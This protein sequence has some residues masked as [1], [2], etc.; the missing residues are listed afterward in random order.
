MKDGK[1]WTV[2]E[3]LT[4]VVGNDEL[5]Y[6]VSELEKNT[7]YRFE[8]YAITSVDSETGV[9]TYSSV[10]R[11][12]GATK[13]LPAV[14]SVKVA[15][16][17]DTNSYLAITWTTVVPGAEYEIG[18]WN[19]TNRN[20]RFIPNLPSGVE[21]VSITEATVNGRITVTALLSGVTVGVPFDL[22]IRMAL[23][24]VQEGAV[25]LGQQGTSARAKVNV[26]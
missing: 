24:E 22:A 1:V 20:D 12:N 5:S 15:R 25:V 17:L 21:V 4:I 23:P 7:K 2:Q 13:V 9:N 11:A 19:A 16:S 26:K 3:E 14:K 6:L 10:A 18:T 8:V